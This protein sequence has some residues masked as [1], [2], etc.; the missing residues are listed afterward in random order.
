MLFFTTSCHYC[1]LFFKYPL[2]RRILLT[3][4][5]NLQIFFIFIRIPNYIGVIDDDLFYF[6]SMKVQISE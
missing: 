3:I 2:L 6:T 5:D 4:S 1:N